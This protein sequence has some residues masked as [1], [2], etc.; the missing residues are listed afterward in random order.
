MASSTFRLALLKCSQPVPI[1][2]ETVGDYTPIF[3]TMLEGSLD[4]INS[5][6]TGM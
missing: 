5:S 1:I 6:R 4:L 3:Q 2:L